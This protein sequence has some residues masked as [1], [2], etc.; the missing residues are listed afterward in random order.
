MIC[1]SSQR[2]LARC[3]TH[4]DDHSPSLVSKLQNSSRKT[5][6][7]HMGLT[8]KAILCWGRRWF[9]FPPA[10]PYTLMRRELR[11]LA[12]S[13]AHNYLLFTQHS[14]SLNPKTKWEYLHTPSLVS[15]PLGT[16]TPIRAQAAHCTITTIWFSSTISQTFLTLRRRRAFQSP[17]I[18]FE[19]TQTSVKTISRTRPPR[20]RSKTLTVSHTSKRSE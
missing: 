20:W 18:N 3:A 11:R 17:Y 13:C 16:N 2:A 7:I 1:P 12:P 14:P 19:V 5:G 8:S 6:S 9:T 10:P 15:K 4:R